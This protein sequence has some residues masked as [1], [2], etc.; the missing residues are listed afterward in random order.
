MP[1]ILLAAAA[2]RWQVQ[3]EPGPGSRAQEY[4]PEALTTT[5]VRPSPPARPE[6]DGVN[7]TASRSGGRAAYTTV[8]GDPPV[9]TYVASNVVPLVADSRPVHVSMMP[10]LPCTVFLIL[11]TALT[12][13]HPDSPRPVSRRAAPTAA[14]ARRP[15]GRIAGLLMS[16]SSFRGR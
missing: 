14:T 1:T 6:P 7:V 5:S 2:L 9:V 11:L 13:P 4:S 15:A 12:T 3:C 16:R 10:L 8:A